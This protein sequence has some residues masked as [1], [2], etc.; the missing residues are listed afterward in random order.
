MYILIVLLLHNK[1]KQFKLRLKMRNL[2]VIVLLVINLVLGAMPYYSQNSASLTKTEKQLE[3]VSF[4][5]NYIHNT[6]KENIILKTTKLLNNW[7]IK[8]HPTTTCLFYFKTTKILAKTC[9]YGLQVL[10]GSFLN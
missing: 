4:L 3:D 7:F 6:Q 9:K 5:E 1:V 10:Y 2:T 8:T